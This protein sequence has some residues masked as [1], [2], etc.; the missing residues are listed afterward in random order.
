MS[1]VPSWVGDLVRE[2]CSISISL[3][4]LYSSGFLKIF[5]VNLSFIL[6]LKVVGN[7]TSVMKISH[8]SRKQSKIR[9]KGKNQESW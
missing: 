3:F 4:S 8:K 2:E 7:K 5:T 6:L 9:D 1:S